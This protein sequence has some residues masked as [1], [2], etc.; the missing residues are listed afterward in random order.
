MRSTRS[1]EQSGEPHHAAF[2]RLLDAGGI[3]Y[4]LEAG[5]GV[6][7]RPL[8]A[9]LRRTF[10]LLR[11]GSPS[12]QVVEEHYSQDV[13]HVYPSASF[14][15]LVAVL[16]DWGRRI[17][18]PVGGAQTTSVSPTIRARFIGCIPYR[19]FEFRRR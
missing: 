18:A 2:T 19:R 13:V 14:E 15:G 4:T 16:S 6:F 12:R 10:D 3:D 11:H 17:H 5:G 9:V 8:V 1:S 7:S